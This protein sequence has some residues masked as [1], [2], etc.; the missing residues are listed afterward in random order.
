MPAYGD[1]VAPQTIDDLVVLIKSWARP[2]M[3]QILKFRTRFEAAVIN[4]GG[5]MANSSCE[6]TALRRRKRYMMQ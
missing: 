4:E 2:S 3:V 6:R 1:Q 5:P